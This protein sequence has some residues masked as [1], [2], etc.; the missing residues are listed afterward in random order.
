MDELDSFE[1]LKK[2]STVSVMSEERQRREEGWGD[3][4]GQNLCC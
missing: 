3:R 4:L 1:S 2:A